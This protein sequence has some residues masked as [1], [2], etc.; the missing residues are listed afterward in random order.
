MKQFK[1]PYTSMQYFSL[2][3]SPVHSFYDEW[4]RGCDHWRF[5]SWDEQLQTFLKENNAIRF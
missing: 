1:V 4:Y 2:S 5:D 3:S